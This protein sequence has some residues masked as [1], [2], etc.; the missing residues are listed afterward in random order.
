MTLQYETSSFTVCDTFPKDFCANI[1][2]FRL[3]EQVISGVMV[4]C[5]LKRLQN[6]PNGYILKVASRN[7]DATFFKHCKRIR[8]N[9]Q[10]TCILTHNFINFVSVNEF[11]LALQI[12]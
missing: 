8:N 7:W 5:N 11:L 10:E 4:R 12:K 3:E 2:F 6:Q 1:Y 9:G